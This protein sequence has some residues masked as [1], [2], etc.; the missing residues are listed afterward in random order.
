MKKN[1]GTVLILVIIIGMV[2]LSLTVVSVQLSLAQKDVQE[3]QE[4][5]FYARQITE[6][7]LAQALVKIREGGLVS[8]HSGGDASPA[9]VQFS[10]GQFLYYATYDAATNVNTVRAWGRIPGGSSPSGSTCAPDAAGWDGTGWALQGSELTVKS[11]RYVPET[12]AYFGNGGIQ[13]P[14]G[15]FS[16]GSGVDP[17]NPAT[18]VPV[19]GSP[20]SYQSNWVPFE[21]SALDHPIDYIYN[22]G[23]PTPA[24]TCPHPYKIMMSQ[25][26]I[27]QYNNEAWLT[28]SAGSGVDP[29]IKVTPA[30]TS[31]NY[32]TSDPNSPD[33]PYA[34]DANVP[35]VQDL[36][37]ELWRAHQSDP[38]AN[39]LGTGAHEGEYGTLAQPKVTFVTGELMVAANKQFR[40]CGILV[41][42]DNYDPN[43]QTNNTPATYARMTIDGNFEWTG[44]VI[45]V[46]WNPSINIRSTAGAQA[47][48]VGGLFGEDSVQS[49]GEISL[50]SA[51]IMTT[52]SNP[53][54]LLYSN[55]LF[56]E[57]GLLN[58][59]LP[60][61]KR[62]IVGIREI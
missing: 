58:Q 52:V 61:V 59:Y 22:G 57:G 49:S 51:A 4:E 18:W 30:P 5:I 15:G 13:K 48:I 21:I 36:A 53:L 34:I 23:S 12:P 44:L 45:V 35:N 14:L 7:A 32:D 33:Y 50:N 60:M 16:W 11:R 26:G 46:G 2:L 10:R 55:G 38:A 42:R 1:R 62:E 3:T 6:S 25:N 56:R 28:K 17:T 54:R 19:T 43:T 40:G 31:A 39:L 8:F 47:T 20:D 41:I 27:G 24:T 29:T 9:W 37:F